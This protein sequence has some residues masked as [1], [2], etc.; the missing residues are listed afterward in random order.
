MET[1]TK[2]QTKFCQKLAYGDKQ[3]PSV[4]LGIVL[5]ENSNFLIFKT[6]NKEYRI[7][8]SLIL[9]LESTNIPFKENGGGS[10]VKG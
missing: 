4:I 5:E 2:G 10:D 7:S 3:E 9:S 8:Q 1:K 6:A